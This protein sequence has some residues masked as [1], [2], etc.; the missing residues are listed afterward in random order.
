MTRRLAVVAA[1][2]A[3]ASGVA[4]ASSGSVVDTGGKPIE[5]V[6]AC[7]EAGAVIFHTVMLVTVMPARV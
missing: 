1:L 3:L 7:A 4:L 6:K 5:G 2:C